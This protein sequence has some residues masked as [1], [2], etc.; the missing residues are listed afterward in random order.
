MLKR[1]YDVLMFD[2]DGTIADTD[3]MLFETFKILYAKYRNG[4]SKSKEEIYYFSGPPIRDTLKNEFPEVDQDILFKEFHDIS[5]SFYDTHIFP[6]PHCREVLKELKEDGFHLAVVTN[7]QHDLAVVV[8]K[9]LHLDDLIDYVVGFNDVSKGKPDKEGIMK[10]INHYGSDISKA[11]Y[12]GDNALDFYTAENAQVDC[13]L[14]NWGPRVLPS[15]IYP[16]Y[17]ISSY[18]DLKEKVYEQGI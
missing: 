10:A 17:K 6:Y 7:K 9:N 1:K 13:C 8:L 15:D 3:P 5:Y 11:L 4:K 2:M 12:V 18:L 14:V 16:K